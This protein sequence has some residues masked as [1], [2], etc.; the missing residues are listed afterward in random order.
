MIESRPAGTGGSLR[1]VSLWE[2]GS[3]VE[4]PLLVSGQTAQR[5]EIL[6]K[7]KDMTLGSFIR[8]L[9][10]ESLAREQPDWMPLCSG[11]GLLAKAGFHECPSE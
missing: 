1:A 11:T 6:A 5:L 7:Q 10:Y 2:P 8:H 9:L 3:V 4:L